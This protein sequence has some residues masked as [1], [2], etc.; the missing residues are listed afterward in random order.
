MNNEIKISEILK[1]INDHE[2]RISKIEGLLKGE[3]P[4]TKKIRKE[5]INEFIKRMKPDSETMTTL[6]IGYFLEIREVVSPFTKAEVEAAYRNAHLT[7]PKNISLSITNNVRKAFF[8]EYPE[9]RDG[10]KAWI[11]TNTGIECVEKAISEK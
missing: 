10:V 3:K 11:L 5:T 9:L 1:R 7:L 4:T 6:Y 2:R 8:G